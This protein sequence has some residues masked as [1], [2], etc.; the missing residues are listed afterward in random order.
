MSNMDN[1]YKLFG[2]LSNAST[3]NIIMAY[4]NKIT[5]YNNIKELS[6]QDIY[7]IKKLKI[8]L[9]ILINL[10]VIYN[11]ILD[12]SDNSDN[13]D[14]SDKSDKL[15]NE[16][17]AINSINEDSIDSLFKVD[18]IWMN[19]KIHPDKKNN[20]ETNIGDRV[21]SLNTLNNRHGF[22]YDCE[23]NLRN[24]LQGRQ[25]KTSNTN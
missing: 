18:N 23:T 16:P 15:D 9:Y 20:F 17:I 12:K 24:P 25:D 19:D 22:S 8:G 10:R 1:F 4:E 11:Q 21:F 13:S 2:V 6:K 5:K 3:N 7:D 14:N